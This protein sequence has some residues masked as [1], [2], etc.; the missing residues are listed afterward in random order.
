MAFL[1]SKV[2]NTTLPNSDDQKMK[3][4]TTEENGNFNQTPVST[5]LYLRSPSSSKSLEK[6]AVLR[7]I[8][9]HKY[10]SKIKGTLEVLVRSSST[11]AQGN[12]QMWV[13]QYDGF[14]TP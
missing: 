14:S 5:E 7:R 6:E 8:R 1:I 2:E 9:H 12:E 4:N 10:I 13:D 11:T 3:L